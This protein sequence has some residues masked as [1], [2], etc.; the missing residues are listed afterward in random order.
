MAVAVTDSAGSPS[1]ADCRRVELAD[2][3]VVDSAQPYH[4]GLELPARDAKK[5]V[6]RL[7]AAVERFSR[8]S[9]GDLLA[10]YGGSGRVV[11]I[12]LVVG[13]DVD[14]AAI[15]N[16]HIRAHAS[17]GRLFRRVIEEASAERGLA[18]EVTVEKRLYA[19]AAKRLGK[20]EP[21]LK[22]EINAL[23]RGLER[24]WRAEEKTAALAAW[25]VLASRGQRAEST[26]RRARGG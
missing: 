17:E 12:G 10:Q 6:D 21:Q 13:S 19:E 2:P 25:M 4:A 7:V 15:A 24:P 18:A 14:P 1:I 23:G 5:T 11:G 20:P 9:V 8:R 22:N 3:D 16:D 26:S